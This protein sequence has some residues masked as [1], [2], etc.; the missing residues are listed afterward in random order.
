VRAWKPPFNPEEVTA[1]CA[2][3]LKPYH[4]RSVVGDNY[5]G[6]WPKEQ[7]RKHGIAYQVSEKNRSQLY[8]DLI[9]AVNSQRVELPDIRQMIDELRRLERRRGRSG[10]D[11][12]DHPAYG[13]SD[14]VANAVAGA[15]NLIIA[16]PGSIL[17]QYPIGVGKAQHFGSLRDRA[18]AQPLPN[19]TFGPAP[20]EQRPNTGCAE[21]YH[22]PFSYFGRKKD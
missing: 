19:S 13:G 15:V 11:S 18:I 8:L 1:Q 3:A 22:S 6:E 17:S 4:V 16:K 20:A 2:E 12:V 5:G 9:P 7:F 21:L 10:K 14:D